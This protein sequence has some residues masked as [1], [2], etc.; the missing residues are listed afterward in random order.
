MNLARF[1]PLILMNT[2]KFLPWTLAGFVL[3]A[4]GTL[5]LAQD[6]ENLVQNGDFETGDING[7]YNGKGATVV[8]GDGS[9]GALYLDQRESA[10]E[11]VGQTV[12]LPDGARKLKLSM[13]AKTEGL[14]AG[15]NPWDTAKLS[16]QFQ[17][18]KGKGVGGWGGLDAPQNSGWKTPAKEIEV[19]AG[20]TQI[21]LFPGMSK[22][23]RGQAWFDDIAL[24]VAGAVA[25]EAAPVAKTGGNLVN[26]SDFSGE[27]NG[28]FNGKDVVFKTVNGD[29]VA[30][31][32][33]TD[34]TKQGPGQAVD[35][36]A[37]A[38]QVGV[39]MRV[40]V[41][42]LS[43]GANAWD[44]PRLTWRFVDDGGKQSGGWDGLNV[45]GNTP[46][47]TVS[48]DVAVPKGAAKMEI[49]VGISKGAKAKFWFDDVKIE[50]A[51]KLAAQP[52]A[53]PAKAQT[54]AL[55]RDDKGAF[56]LSLDPKKYQL[57]SWNT[58]A[59]NQDGAL[60][61]QT[62][63]RDWHQFA[64]TTIE[65]EGA[66]TRLVFS[67]RMK[68]EN[69]TGGAAPIEAARAQLI[70]LDEN[71]GQ[72]DANG[73]SCGGGNSIFADPARQTNG[74]YPA[75]TVRNGTTDWTP[76]TQEHQLPPGTKFVET[77]LGIYVS[78]GVVSFDDLKMS[79]TDAK[80]QPVAV[81]TAPNEVRTDTR[82]WWIFDPGTEDKARPR[83]I[84]F[85]P[86]MPKPAG[87][88]GGVRAKDGHFVFQNGRR[89]RFW[90]TG[91]VW[92]SDIGPFPPK[93]VAD[94]ISA[95]LASQGI[96]LVR[97]HGIESG[98]PER[99]IYQIGTT[100][101]DAAKQD[102]LDYY[103]FA[104]KRE[105]IY[106]NI[107]L[108]TYH[109]FTAAQGVRDADKLPDGG[110][111]AIFFNRRLI[112]L[113]KEFARKLLTHVNAYTKLAYKDDPAIAMVELKNES[114]L[115]SVEFAGG[116][117]D[118][119]FDELDELFTAWCARNNETRPDGKIRI[120][121]RGNNPLVERFAYDVTA[122]YTR[123]MTDFLKNE[124]GLKVPISVTQYTKVAG[125]VKAHA[126]ADYVDRHGYWDIPIGGW[127]VTDG[128]HNG[129]IT[130]AFLR[131]DTLPLELAAQRVAGKPFTI[132][133]WNFDWPNEY[134]T[135]GPIVMAAMGGFQDWDAPM[136]FLTA[137]K[138]W[139]PKIESVFGIES[140]PHV[141]GS[142]I[143]SGLMFHRGDIAPGPELVRPL[144][145][146][147]GK[148]TSKQ[149]SRAEIL[150]HRVGLDATR[151]Q[152]A[153]PDVSPV[154]N[155]LSSADGQLT[156]KDGL[157][158]I[159]T[160]R[161]QGFVG[162]TRGESVNADAVQF[163]CATPFAQILATSLDDAPLASAK[164]V[165]ISATARAEN[166][167]QVYKA[168]KKGLKDAGE[169]PIRMEPVRAS[170]TLARVA[171]GPM[172][173]VYLAD[174]Y[175]RR[176]SKTLPVVAAGAKAWKVDLAGAPAL[177]FEVVFGD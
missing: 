145:V 157:L 62:K 154:K 49:F 177:W 40:K 162:F 99:S 70:F 103:I 56:R 63:Q 129:S 149:F 150:T 55:P 25:A 59:S 120:L 72:L 115:H 86:F 53:A 67:G 92:G 68:T 128:F 116:L 111:A 102:S 139:Q 104:L 166:T 146:D 114:S 51:N 143:S 155:E 117:P 106:S 82:D 123:E 160:P 110:G 171:A 18:A 29:K 112:E 105:G 141:I 52:K 169:G 85:T 74:C 16:F 33:Q 4:S 31:L 89:A 133:E 8:A 66:P 172:P 15:D 163:D 84:D 69:V 38:S 61:L 22:S 91:N 134:I 148:L 158:I 36:P 13:R 90:G 41:E 164:R 78:T 58:W 173:T 107:N 47:K 130:R 1:H 57:P 170:V 21:V 76:F 98:K 3:L 65:L 122:D 121:L 109:K 19:P 126:L 113:Q 39:S 138:G 135:E 5:L 140:K 97:F 87:Q 168:F 153:T 23:A 34:D 2:P 142:L 132:S 73:D 20:A 6:A 108:L 12:K 24:E 43:Q 152:A 174:A 30:Y 167:G 88:F 101:F 144:P 27:L 156:W 77:M 124:I 75:G 127:N 44:V 137:G 10:K 9:K 165:L 45:D 83:V 176:T 125:D 32:E 37:G 46:W 50:V 136:I 100:Q 71:G 28:W 96:N 159:N 26:N 93:A 95:R 11:G 147:L 81:E 79:A 175:G 54:V 131:S 151:Q 161:S 35:L 60:R 119:Y 17:D 80:G 42:G 94:D 48:R 118:S 14:V 7:W 64:R